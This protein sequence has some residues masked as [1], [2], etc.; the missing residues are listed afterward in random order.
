MRCACV[1]VAACCGAAGREAMAA[2]CWRIFSA[3][4]SGRVVGASSLGFGAK[5]S[6]DWG[7]R[8]DEL[9]YRRWER[10]SAAASW[11]VAQKTQMSRG[12]DGC[13]RVRDGG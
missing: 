8:L 1:M 12:A 7:A 2:S 6:A 11:R 3:W 4:V 10:A 13:V 9:R 5:A